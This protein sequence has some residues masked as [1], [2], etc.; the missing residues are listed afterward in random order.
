MAVSSIPQR[1]LPSSARAPAGRR[2]TEKRASQTFIGVLLLTLLIFG[3]WVIHYNPISAK[4]HLEDDKGKA[5]SISNL[6]MASALCQKQAALNF[7]GALVDAIVDDFSTRYDRP[8]D[9]FVV[10]LFVSV[11]QPGR[12]TEEYRT[13]CHVTPNDTEVHYYRGFAVSN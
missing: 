2:T 4:A 8:R 5:K 10:L 13:H 9:L 1:R 11:Y 12:V 3:W 6:F 7:Q